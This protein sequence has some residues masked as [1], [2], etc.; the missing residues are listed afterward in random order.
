MAVGVLRSLPDLSFVNLLDWFM[1]AVSLAVAA[2]SE[3]LA[4]VV[5]IVLSMGVTN[6][7]KKNAII[8]KMTAVETLGCTQV[9]CSDKTGTLAQNR[10]TVIEASCAADEK[11]VATS[12][13]LCTDASPDES[14]RAVGEPTQCAVVDWA[15]DMGL[16]KGELNARFPR[17]G[18]LPFDS[19]RKMMTTLH[20]LPEGSIIQH[21]SGAPDVILSRCAYV[22]E[23]D[24]V[25]P[26]TE[27]LRAK[28][29]A[30]NKRLADQTL[31]VIA[32]AYVEHDALPAVITTEALEHDLIFIGLARLMDPS[33]PRS[34]WQSANARRRA[35]DP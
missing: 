20:K 19:D 34:R 10:M 26:M 31:R 29:V 8:R 9:I 5:T 14:G 12:F 22:K 30:E 1:V 15:A 28:Y 16:P 2:I 35:S 6:M 23:G 18:E 33:V 25:V 3:G 32:A 27:G 7:S 11:E 24:T 17:V 13:L 21:T 4:T